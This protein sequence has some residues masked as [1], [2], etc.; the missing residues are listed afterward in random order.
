VLK[1]KSELNK[2]FIKL[3]S[4]TAIGQL[5]PLL[6]AP[7]ISRLFTPEEIGVYALYSSIVSVAINIVCLKLDQAIVLPKLRSEALRLYNIANK[8]SVIFS[9]SAVMILTGLKVFAYYGM[10]DDFSYWWFLLGLHIFALGAYQSATYLL[11][12][13]KD[14][15]GISNS[16]V[17][18]GLLNPITQILLFKLNEWGLVLGGFLSRLISS[19]YLKRRIKKANISKNM[20]LNKTL[21]L[22]KFDQTLLKKYRHFPLYTSTNSLLNSFSNQLPVFLLDRFY[23]S[24]ITG[25]YSWSNRIIQVPMGFITSSMY[26]VF[27]QEAASTVA[28]GEKIYDLI[29][30]T[31]KKLFLIAILPYTLVFIFAP[32]IFSLVFGSQWREA[33]EFTRYLIPWFFV[34]FL[35]SPITAVIL[36]FDKQKQHLIFE[37]ILFILRVGSLTLGYI[38]WKSSHHSIILFG[39][40]GFLYNIFLLI[41]LLYLTKKRSI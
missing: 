18:N 22:S 24:Y 35:N 14:F 20:P 38:L 28:K 39:I 12:R 4:G 23:S 9:A 37:I 30:Q 17:I 29:A 3:F 6:C 2:N 36:I 33:G 25:L 27:Y 15:T 19:F 34:S 26:Q 40:V 21:V 10:V 1:I 16:R 5:V 32:Q 41:Y 11:N 13:S 31:Y 7:I 8:I